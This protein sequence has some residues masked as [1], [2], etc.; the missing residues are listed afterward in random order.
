[1][2]VICDFDQSFLI[3]NIFYSRMI[4][5]NHKM[6]DILISYFWVSNHHLDDK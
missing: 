6:T 3:V 5:K 1:M 2:S 4:D